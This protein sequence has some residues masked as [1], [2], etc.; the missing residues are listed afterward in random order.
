MHI[1]L[2]ACDFEK[3]G[4]VDLAWW[5][6]PSA[7]AGLRIMQSLVDALPV[8]AEPDPNDSAFLFLFDLYA[9][10]GDQ[11]AQ[12]GK[13]FP[14]QLAQRVAPDQVARWLAERPD[15]DPIAGRFPPAAARH[16]SASLGGHDT[17]HELATKK[18]SRR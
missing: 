9:E 14:L 12:A 18:P 2:T 4:F 5:A 11:I 15:P 16:P 1:Q 7:Q 17:W 3:T 8:E 10:P 13:L 6:V